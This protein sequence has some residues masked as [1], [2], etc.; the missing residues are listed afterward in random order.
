[1]FKYES[2]FG[3]S[4]IEDLVAMQQDIHPA[5]CSGTRRD[6]GDSELISIVFN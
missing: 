1:M 2:Y 4:C 3:S 6:H 5:P